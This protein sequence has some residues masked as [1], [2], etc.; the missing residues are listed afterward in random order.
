MP[1]NFLARPGVRERHLKRQ[2]NNPLFAQTQRQFDQQRLSGAR[3]MDEKEAAEFTD[4]FHILLA[5]VAKLKPNE[6]SEVLLDLKSRLDE[7][8][9]L[10]SGLSGDHT[11][12]QQA[13]NKLV[14]VIMRSISQSAQ[15]DAE[16]IQ[17]LHEEELARNTHFQLL[18]FPLVADLLR[19]R[20]P[21]AQDQLVATLLS[22]SGEALQ[23][24]F[25]LFDREHQQL[26]YQQA[27]QLLQA[28][29][30]YSAQL[31]KAHE[32]LQLMAQLL[33]SIND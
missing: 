33:A 11:N 1:L 28:K 7:S 18:S 27:E 24:A 8:Y 17:N 6:G 3:Y 25:S 23:A 31:S 19:P 21:I 12:E 26:I 29:A 15:G 2:Y 20:S 16:A 5:E 14:Q 32:Q 4:K 9:E 13:I 10:C 22:E 30:K